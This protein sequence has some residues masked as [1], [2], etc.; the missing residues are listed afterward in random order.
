MRKKRDG[1]RD[2]EAVRMKRAAK[3]RVAEW[4]KKLAS[5]EQEPEPEQEQDPKPEPEPELE[6]EP[7]PE[8][9]PVPAPPAPQSKPNPRSSGFISVTT[10]RR[11]PII[12]PQPADSTPDAQQPPRKNVLPIRRLANRYPPPPPPSQVEMKYNVKSARGGRGGRVTAVASIWAEASKGGSATPANVSPPKP[13]LSAQSLR[14]LQPSAQTGRLHQPRP[15][16]HTSEISRKR[17]ATATGTRTGTARAIRSRRSCSCDAVF[18]RTI[19]I[20]RYA[21]PFI[22]CISRTAASCSSCSCPRSCDYPYA[23]ARVG[24]CASACC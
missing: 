16:P 3:G 15:S 5:P 12:L 10:L 13:K 6:P 21:C 24:A 20:D 18:T 2:E 14:R 9:E 7:E 17:T 23:R 4:L 11:A 8:P 22:N 1:G 19:V